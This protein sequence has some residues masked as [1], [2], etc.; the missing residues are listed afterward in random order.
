MRIEISTSAKVHLIS[1]AEIHAIISFPALRL[2]LAGRREGARPVLYVGP[3]VVNQPWIEV[4]AD[5]ADAAVA[6][7]FH[8]MM[9]RRSLVR[10]VGIDDLI[11]PEY[12]PQR[13]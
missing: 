11:D 13:A 4:I 10:L 8:A 6:D 5:H 9:L 3:A 7:A 1:D 12:G 2:P